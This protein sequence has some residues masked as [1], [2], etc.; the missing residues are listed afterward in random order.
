MPNCR[1]ISMARVVRDGVM[2]SF[3]FCLL[4]KGD[5]IEM[6][7]GDIAPADAEY[8]YLTAPPD[9]GERY[10]LKQGQ[11]FRPAAFWAAT[12]NGWTEKMFEEAKHAQGR[13]QFRLQQ[14]PLISTIRDALNY[15]RPQPLIYQQMK[16]F[17]FLIYQRLI[18]ILLA[19]A[20]LFNVVR[21]ALTPARHVTWMGVL[22]INSVYVIIPLLPFA[23]YTA[24]AL[25]RALGNARILLL[26]DQ[27]QQSL[28]PFDDSVSVDEFDEEA[29]PPTKDV[30]VASSTL[31]FK[32]LSI[33]RHR[34]DNALMHSS[35]LVESL[36]STSVICSVDREGT[37]SSIFPTMEQLYFFAEEQPQEPAIIDLTVDESDGGRLIVE[38]KDWRRYLN[39]LRPLG[40]NLLLNTDCGAAVTTTNKTAATTT[41]TTNTAAVKPKPDPHRKAAHLVLHGCPR[42][43]R[44]SCNCVLAREIGGLAPET[45]GHYRSSK[46]V[47]LFDPRQLPDSTASGSCRDD[48]FEVPSCTMKILKD[49]RQGTDFIFSD[50]SLKILEF[51]SDYW[52]GSTVQ[53]LTDQVSLSDLSKR[54]IKTEAMQIRKKIQDFYHNATVNDSQCVLYSYSP[55]VDADDQLNALLKSNREYY[56]FT[57]AMKE[58][59]QVISNQI[60]LCLIAMGHQPKEV[61]CY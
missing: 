26:F 20:I 24:W 9:T 16:R 41:A 51:C 18:W 21:F 3:P 35:S 42:P 32:F 33:L 47:Y 22:I 54:I 4:V 28:T 50:G 2:R 15:R 13:Y 30:S 14:T 49:E 38:E 6:S 17:Y 12:S 61:S 58:F 36:G 8:V 23:A 1:A 37:I 48:Q 29:L 27:L 7:F 25:T 52:D 55:I 11:M 57:E 31:L 10:H 43:A 5:V 40:L 46:D 34:G 59:D 45:L 56:E 19:I 53:P 60:F 44:Q 39:T